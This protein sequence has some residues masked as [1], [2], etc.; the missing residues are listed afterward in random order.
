VE[1]GFHP[2]AWTS[3][4][5]KH[6]VFYD[7]PVRSFIRKL[8]RLD[9]ASAKNAFMLF[10]AAKVLSQEGL[11]EALRNVLNQ[12]GGGSGG[13]ASLDVSKGNLFSDEDFLANLRE[14]LKRALEAQE[15]VLERRSCLV[16]EKT[17]VGAVSLLTYAANLWHWL[18]DTSETPG[19]TEADELERTAQNLD[20]AARKLSECFS[21]DLGPLRP[22]APSATRSGR[23]RTAAGV[24]DD[25][26]TMTPQKRWDIVNRASRYSPK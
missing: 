9:L 7:A 12:R 1:D 13:S 15:S 22:V 17:A 8:L 18:S 20:S 19:P 5:V 21:V 14:L 4:V 25:D 10:R 6:A 16:P 3:F 23:R 26:T 2:A 24:H 11:P